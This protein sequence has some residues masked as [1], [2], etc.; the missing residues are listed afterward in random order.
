MSIVVA[1][2]NEERTIRAC[3]EGLLA[4]RYPRVEVIVVDDGSTDATTPILAEL[5]GAAP[6][7]RL[8]VLRG[9]ARGPGAARNRGVRAAHGD[10]VAFIDG[11]AVA[12][13]DWVEALVAALGDPDLAS[14]GGIQLAPDTATAFQRRIQRFFEAVGFVSDYVRGDRQGVV[15]TDHNPSCNS[16]YRRDVFDAHGGFRED[17]F[18]CEDLELDRRLALRGDRIG[19]CAAARVFHERPRDLADFAGMMRRYGAAHRRLVAIHGRFRLLHWLPIVVPVTAGGLVALVVVSP[20]LALALGGAG[21][22]A[23]LAGLAARGGAAAAPDNA[24]LLGVAV[25]A[26]LTGYWAG[27]R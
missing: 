24:W 22:L 12:A 19:F 27:K 11:D 26:W 21:L 5:A 14:V 3:V 15:P 8:T 1:A 20:P 25:A 13:P 7:G 23:A 6:P 2:R 10:V 18:P 9:E 16:A 4:Q 17:L